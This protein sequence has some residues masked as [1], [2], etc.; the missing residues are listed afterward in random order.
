MK[1]FKNWTIPGTETPYTLGQTSE[2]VPNENE[3]LDALCG[4]YKIFQ[5]K[6][7]HRYSTDDLIVAGFASNHTT[8]ATRC[9]DLGSGISS[10]AMMVAWRLPHTQWV[11]V[12]AQEQSFALAK[13][14]IAIN[15]L[16]ERFDQRLGDFRSDVL[17]PEEKFD[18][19]TGSPPYFK[20]NGGVLAEHQQ[21]VQC[22]FEARG[23]VFDYL[24][25]AS[26]H[27]AP[28]GKV[29]VVFPTEFENQWLPNIGEIGLGAIRHQRVFFKEGVPPL[30][31]LY[32]FGR[33]ADYPESF[34]QKTGPKGFEEPAMTIRRANG[35]VDLGYICFKLSMGFQ[36]WG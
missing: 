33:L 35:E 16:R 21:K 6:D 34:F 30:L 32:Q 5:L 15:N 9:L 8:Q 28:A 17:K 29:C 18:L 2:F 24:E 23:G 31:S 19:I 14:N 11:T 13:K 4:H 27:L 12:E 10:V 20:M 25:T 1:Q 22:R 7:G 26:K 3:S 36:P